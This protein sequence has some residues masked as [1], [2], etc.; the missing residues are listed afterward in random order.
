[1]RS[2]HLRSRS[3]STRARISLGLAVLW[4]LGFEVLPWLHVAMHRHLGKHHHDQSGAVIRDDVSEAP[5]DDR[6]AVVDEHAPHQHDEHDE[7][8]DGDPAVDEHD[9]HDEHDVDHDGDPAVDEHDAHD[10]HDE[11]HDGDPA[12]DEHGAS[13]R[14]S[15]D[16]APGRAHG[17][18]AVASHQRA[19]SVA[20]AALLLEKL[21]RD[22]INHGKSS[23]AHHD[24]A[25]TTPALVLTTPLPVNRRPI[26]LFEDTA[27]EPY[28]FSPGRAVARGP[29]AAVF[30]T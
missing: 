13:P 29:P 19:A 23:L 21:V 3:C 4:L 6:D 24:V 26:F 20:R 1:M 9:A 10:E 18:H 11:D 14:R 22:A 7:D 5:D 2:Q 27:I 25:T 12:V 15:A 28:S 16:G 17:E 30:E 8:H